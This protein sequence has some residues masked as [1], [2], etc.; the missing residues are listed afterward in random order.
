MFVFDILSMEK[1]LPE[2][3][4]SVKELQEARKEKY[5]NLS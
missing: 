3:F 4:D 1:R 2:D 5:D